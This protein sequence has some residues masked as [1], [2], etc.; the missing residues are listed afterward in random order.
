MSK[1]DDAN[2]DGK[3]MMEILPLPKPMFLFLDL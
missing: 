1:M 3:L 2:D